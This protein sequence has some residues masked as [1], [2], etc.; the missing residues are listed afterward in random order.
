MKK[1]DVPAVKKKNSKVVKANS[2]QDSHASLKT[3]GTRGFT[4]NEGEFV[5]REEA[6]K[7]AKKAKQ[8]KSGKDKVEKTGKLHSSNLRKEKK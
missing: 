3:K 5:E 6:A 7:I 1:I 8:I 2:K 4:T